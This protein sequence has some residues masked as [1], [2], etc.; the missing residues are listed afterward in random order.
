MVH[1]LAL[2]DHST[3]K[4]SEKRAGAGF[5]ANRGAQLRHFKPAPNDRNAHGSLYI[6]TLVMMFVQATGVWYWGPANAFGEITE[7]KIFGVPFQYLLWLMSFFV[8]GICFNLKTAPFSWRP[9]ALFAIFGAMAIPLS[10]DILGS[11]RIFL[12]WAISILVASSVGSRLPSKIVSRLVGQLLVMALIGSVL[13][14]AALPGNGMEDYGGTSVLR[15]LFISKNACGWIGAIGFVWGVFGRDVSSTLRFLLIVS[16]SVVCLWSGSAGSLVA[17]ILVIPIQYL[18]G[19]LGKTKLST[20]I[21]VTAIALLIAGATIFALFFVGPILELLGRD[22]TLTGRTAI[23]SI[24]MDAA[25]NCQPL[26]CGPGAFS[27]RSEVTEP[28]ARSLEQF[29]VILTP[30]NAYIAA[31]GEGGILGALGF[32]GAIMTFALVDPLSK[33]GSAF[34][35]SSAL[36]MLVAMGGIIETRAVYGI[37]AAFFLLILARTGALRDMEDSA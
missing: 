13:Y 33:R 20:S 5:G 36:A 35:L 14:G 4:P 15:G 19:L 7:E 17:V 6:A 18:L 25:L 31:F 32:V 24:Y 28:L 34:S 12:Q 21:A 3:M 10:Q 37:N 11:L 2:K 9:L 27:G 29:G 1:P 8:I 26:G 30:H 16:G 23:W 22:A